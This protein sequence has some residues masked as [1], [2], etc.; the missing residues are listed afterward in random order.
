MS[1]FWSTH[2][3]HFPGG[4]LVCENGHCCFACEV[5][6]RLR[7]EKLRA[8]TD[9]TL[10]SYRD[11]LPQTASSGGDNWYGK[12]IILSPEALSKRK[13]DP[14]LINQIFIAKDGP[15]VFKQNPAGEIDGYL[16]YKKHISFTVSRAECYG[17][18]TPRAAAYYDDCFFLGLCKLLKI[19]RRKR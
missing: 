16:L 11:A 5:A 13:I 8:R 12:P 15:G 1:R 2:C 3:L 19:E 4:Y 7:I 10:L 18:P 14:H 9:F 17:V 6:D